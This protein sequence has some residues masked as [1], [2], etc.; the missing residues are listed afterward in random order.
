MHLSASSDHGG[1][2]KRELRRLERWRQ[3]H[4]KNVQSSTLFGC[5][6]MDMITENQSISG[7]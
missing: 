2:G 6:R 3:L 5:I 7:A 1:V 4:E